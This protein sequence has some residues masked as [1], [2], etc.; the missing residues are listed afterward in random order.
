[1]FRHNVIAQ[2]SA[3]DGRL[4]TDHFEKAALFW[5]E[6]KNR[7]GVC[8]NPVMQFNLDELLVQHDLQALV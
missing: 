5:T 8:I 1:V 7:M 4:V 2:I 6:F 3:D